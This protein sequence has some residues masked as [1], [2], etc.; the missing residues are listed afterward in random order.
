MAELVEDLGF[1]FGYAVIE[2]GLL[3]VGVFCGGA[4]VGVHVEEKILLIVFVLGLGDIG[5]WSSIIL[6]LFLCV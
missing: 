3:F 6:F 2:L 5:I 1:D 4:V